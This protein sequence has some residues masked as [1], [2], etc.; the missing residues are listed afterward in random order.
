MT[1]GLLTNV[2]ANMDSTDFIELLKVLAEKLPE[3]FQRAEFLVEKGALD[4]IIDRRQLRDEL[5][6]L[7]AAGPI[8]A[9]HPA[10]PPA[11]IME[12]LDGGD[13]RL[14]E[15]AAGNPS[16]P[17]AAMEELTARYARSTEPGVT[18]PVS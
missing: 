7:L 6:S 11:L 9:A 8:A 14:A 10:L 18:R 13:E 4:L 5:A 12:L 1:N 2:N 17:A 16:L 15:A 3:G